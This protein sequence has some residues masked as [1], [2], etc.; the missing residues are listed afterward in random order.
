M[1]TTRILSLW[2]VK[3]FLTRLYFVMICAGAVGSV[4]SYISSSAQSH[5]IT[6]LNCTG[7]E[8]SIAS[9]PHNGL[10]NNYAC[11]ISRDANVFCQC[12]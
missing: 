7:N 2:Y 8:T 1:Q 9:C 6:D 12:K 4:I 11:S 10:T 5:A 3:S